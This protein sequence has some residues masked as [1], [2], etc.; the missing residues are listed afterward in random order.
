MRLS[1]NRVGGGSHSVELLS[2]SV[3]GA[4]LGIVGMEGAENHGSGHQRVDK[5]ACGDETRSWEIVRE[6]EGSDPAE[7]NVMGATLGG[8]R[9]EFFEEVATDGL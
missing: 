8:F 2:I 9:K 6:V 3:P 1:R 5:R 4:V 7:E